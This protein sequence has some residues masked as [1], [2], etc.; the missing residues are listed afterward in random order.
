MRNM[1]YV[2]PAYNCRANAV[3]SSANSAVY[4]SAA[5]ILIV[6]MPTRT[7]CFRLQFQYT[8]M[9]E[10]SLQQLRGRKRERFRCVSSGFNIAAFFL[11]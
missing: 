10:R 3:S 11:R 8:I 9:T 4:N 1:S 5:V 6:I 7:F 2:L